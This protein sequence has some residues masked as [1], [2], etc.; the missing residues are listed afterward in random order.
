MEKGGIKSQQATESAQSFQGSWKPRSI[1]KTEESSGCPYCHRAVQAYYA[2]CPHCGRSLTP[3]KCSF[4]G[5]AMKPNS[6]FCTHCGQSSE[7][8]VCPECGTLNSR[9]FCRQ[10]NTPLTPMAQQAMEEAAKDPA[11][12][13]IQEKAAELAE[14]HRQIEELR[15]GEST[16]ELSESDRALLDEYADLLGSLG[17]YE[18]YQGAPKPGASKPQITPKTQ[19][20]TTPAETEKEFSLEE[21]MKAY[22]E[23]AAEMNAAL[24]AMVPP[25]DA[26]PEQQR[27]YYSARKVSK[28]VVDIDLSLYEP[29]VWICNFCGCEHECPAQC[30]R[31]ELGGQWVYRTEQDY[32]EAHPEAG[33]ISLKFED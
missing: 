1:S 22:K 27:D 28:V 2:I 13:A 33:T 10:C 23:K 32:V 17:T 15:N 25:A 19:E 20:R 26:T 4:C 7:G 18:T 21:V 11:F 9:N 24:A 31:P 5:G 29:C 3:G 16:V 30:Y 8:I 14:L 12:M 6:K